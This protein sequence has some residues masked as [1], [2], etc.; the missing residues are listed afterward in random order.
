MPHR[1]RRQTREIHRKVPPP[2]LAPFL[3]RGVLGTTLL[4]MNSGLKR[5]FAAWTGRL[6]PLA[7]CCCLLACLSC[8]AAAPEREISHLYTANCA[9]CHG[10]NLEGGQTDS[11]LDDAWKH[12][13]DDSSLAK[14]I[15]DGAEENGMPT[16]KGL[17]S[18][19]EI[20][21]MV[22]FIREKRDQAA[23]RG[24]SPPKPGADEVIESSRHKFRV[25][26]FLEGLSTPWSMAFLPDGQILIAELPGKLRV[27]RNGGLLPEPVQGT[28]RVRH[29]G[30]GG[31]MEV[32]LHP[33]Y[34]TNKW[35]Y[36]AFSDPG[37]AGLVGM[38]AVVRGRIR[39]N[40]WT[41][42]QTIFRAP[43]TTYRVGGVHFG[44]RLVFQDGYLFF[45]IGERG[46]KEDAQDV[47]RPN[48]KVHRVFD[49]GRIPPD[50]P[51]AGRPGAVP[52]I[53]TFGNR[54][55]QGLDIHPATGD[56]WETEHGPRGGDELNVIRKGLNYGWPVITYGMNYNGTPITD[57]TQKDGLE[58]PVIHWTPS[59]AVCGID[60][61]E[62]DKFPNWKN[63]LFVTGLARQELRRITIKDRAVTGQEVILKDIG[64]VR[65]VASGPD[66]LLYV[67]LNK[68]DKIVRLEP[69]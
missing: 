42:E 47:T 35:V 44:C 46:Q 40:A 60:F 14:I 50:N 61:Y 31:L 59:I 13:A 45:S 30:Q 24:A 7:P 66:G 20:R 1:L 25:S 68:P 19:A 2:Q 21:A 6:A 64:R 11:L 28:P 41:D 54:N 27:A 22:V 56:L 9:G 5:A 34:P 63:D 52:S 43:I 3:T 4:L 16:W 49:D 32:A 62:G 10:V 17:L 38:T 8:D 39:D 67:I 36:L 33:G 69:R 53:W 58:Q 18:E 23:Q 37:P 29:Q 51:F 15:R 65:D 55:P 26:T 57:I 12:G 48:G